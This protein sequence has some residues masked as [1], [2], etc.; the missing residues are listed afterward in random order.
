MKKIK[1]IDLFA[2][3]GGTRIGFQQACEELGIESE[4]VFTSEIKPY[5]V[6]IY[7]HNFSNDEIH[8]DITQIDAKEIPNFDFLLGGFP[9][10]AFSVAGSRK[11]FEDTRGTLFFDVARVI[12]EKKPKGFL[13]EN[14][15]GLVSHDKGRTLQTIINVLEELGYHVD[16][17]VLDSSD[18][19]VAQ[20]RKRIYIIGRSNKKVSLDGFDKKTSVLADIL[21]KGLPPLETE[22]TKKLL[23]LY[24]PSD[25]EGKSIKDKRG[26]STNIH[27]WDLELKGKISKE[28]KELL[29]C[30]LLQRRKKIWAELKGIK[31]M[32]GMPLTLNEIHSFYSFAPKKSLKAMLDDL[33]DKKYL[34]FEHPKDIV[35]NGTREYST[36]VEKGYNIVTGKLSF[37]LN[38]ILDRTHIAPTIVATEADRYGVIDSG[39][40]RRLSEKECLRL[41]G[42]PDWYSSNIKHSHLYDLVGNTVVVPVIK[43]VSLKII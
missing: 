26:G 25:L 41:F 11:G 33:V 15:E 32:D 2:G 36:S 29:N 27:S 24:E 40:I 5:A 37:Q 7:Q 8:G 19:G 21:E 3:L 30:L 10:Q 1:F 17:K 28:Q 18:F 42:Y 23:E 34:S 13:L 35:E 38:K 14:V 16:W 20:R 22:F 39:K 12:K 4:C 6:E 31:W 9:C 43:A